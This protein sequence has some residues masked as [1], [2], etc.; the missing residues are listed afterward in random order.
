MFS[1][2]MLYVEILHYMLACILHVDILHADMLT[3]CMFA[4][5]VGTLH[6]CMILHAN[7]A[8]C[9]DI[10]GMLLYTLCWMYIYCFFVHA[11]WHTHVVSWHGIDACRVSALLTHTTPHM[12]GHIIDVVMYQSSQ[13]QKPALAYDHLYEL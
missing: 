6:V 12:Y 7:P 4:L 3:Y 8:Y 11:S 1:H 2:C 10:Y 9:I 5:H 13:N